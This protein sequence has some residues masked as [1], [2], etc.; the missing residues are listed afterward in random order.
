VVGST[1]VVGGK[2]VAGVDPPG[3]VVARGVVDEETGL[4]TQAQITRNKHARRV[5][6]PTVLAKRLRD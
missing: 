1:A 3:G 6:I 2:V 4:A 5:R